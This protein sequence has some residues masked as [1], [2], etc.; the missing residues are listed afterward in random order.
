VVN[1]TGTARRNSKREK[2]KTVIE[3]NEATLQ[4]LKM[5]KD[6]LPP[7]VDISTTG[8]IRSFTKL[9]DEGKV[10]FDFST[11]SVWNGQKKM[12]KWLSEYYDDADTVVDLFYAIADCHGWIKSTAT[13]VI[14]RLEPLEQP[15]RRRAQERL[16]MRLTS[17]LARTPT[18]KHLILEVGEDPRK[19]MS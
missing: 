16:C 6:Q 8:H 5:E 9:V 13:Q 19:K 3:E 17:L 1:S 4:K 15:K 11:I 14:V 2:L 12:V 18:D 10:M 7:R